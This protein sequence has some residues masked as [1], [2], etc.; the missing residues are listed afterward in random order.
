[1]KKYEDI[2]NLKRPKSKHP[3]MTLTNRAAQFAPFA[4]LSGHGEA[5]SNSSRITVN[6]I[7]I[8]EDKKE[9]IKTKLD[10]ILNTKSDKK[11]LITYFVSD[12]INEGGT[13]QTIK[14]SIKDYDPIY[15]ELILENNKTINLNNIYDID[16]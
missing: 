4:A 15:S 1:M 2:I 6:K 11:I 7:E 10:E 9:I 12:Y 14:E 16:F 3:K 13:Y 5:I 8:S